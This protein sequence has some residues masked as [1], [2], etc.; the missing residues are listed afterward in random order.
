MLKLTSKHENKHQREKYFKNL[1]ICI[2][3]RH[4]AVTFDFYEPDTSLGI[5]DDKDG[6]TRT[7][8][9]LNHFILIVRNHKIRNIKIL[10]DDE[11]ACRFE[12]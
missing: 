12:N 7:A 3:F 9:P 11:L 1:I 4:T 2:S 8:G 5:R 6:K 10:H